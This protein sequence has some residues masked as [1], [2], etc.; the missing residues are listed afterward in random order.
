MGNP[1]SQ[2]IGDMI[3]REISSLILKG[4]KDPRIG[5]VTITGVDVTLDLRHAKIFITVIGEE[6]SKVASLEGLRRAVPFI[7]RHLGRE[8][9]MKFA[10]DLHFEYDKS[11]E[12]GNRIENILK[13]INSDRN[14]DN[15]DDPAT[16]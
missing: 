7:R 4:L 16:D 10:P 12:Y 3:Q 15:S 2:K 6:E 9:R 5:F 11:L 13:E 1:R 8:L 14:D